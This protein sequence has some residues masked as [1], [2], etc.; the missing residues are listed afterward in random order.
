MNKQINNNKDEPR[1]AQKWTGVE[2]PF[3]EIHGVESM[4]KEE[5]VAENSEEWTTRDEEWIT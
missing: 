1:D 5:S 3:Y 4:I 2:L